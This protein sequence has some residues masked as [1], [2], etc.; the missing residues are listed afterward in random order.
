M[1]DA[2]DRVCATRLYL[3]LEASVRGRPAT[4]IVKPALDGGVDV[5]QLRDKSAD[6]PEI[7]TAGTELRAL[8]HERGSLFL[9]NDRPDLALRCGADGVHLG[10][11]DEEVEQV[12]DRVGDRLLIGLSTHSREQIEAAERSSADYFVV[13]PVHET[14]TK[15]GRPAVGLELVRFAAGRQG[16]PWF[17]IGGIDPGNAC[18]VVAAGA[19]RLVVVRAIRDADDPAAAA[20]ALRPAIEREAVVGTAR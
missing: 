10:Q 18:A 19:P 4:E 11:D 7:I 8:C 20:R 14:P 12:R 13:G 6:D 1:S 5:V 9:V 2:I 17:A 16:K 15:P 3:V